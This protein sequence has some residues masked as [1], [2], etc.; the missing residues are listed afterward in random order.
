MVT[1]IALPTVAVVLATSAVDS[2]NP[3]AIGVLILMIST[4]LALSH[5]KKK[6]LWIGAIY[7]LAVYI[8]YLAA[9]LGLLYFIQKLNIAEPIGIVVG[10]LVIILGLIEIKDFW[11][12]GQGFS[13]HIPTSKIKTIKKYVKNASVPGAILLGIFVAAVELPCTGGPYLAIT[14]ILAKIGLNWSIF[15]LLMLY[16]LIFVLPLIIILLIAYFGVSAKSISKWK[17][18]YRK[19]MRLATGLIMICLGILLILFA[20]GIIRFGVAG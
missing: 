19:W 7:I 16:N 13:L 4:L 20:K 10:G 18:K 14:T 6:M 8:A 2:I 5:D 9:G 11:W 1:E 3:C 15:R 12:Y 17:T